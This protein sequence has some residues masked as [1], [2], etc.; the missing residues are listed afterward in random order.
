MNA[1]KGLANNVQTMTD[2][3]CEC[4]YGALRELLA[5]LSLEKTARTDSSCKGSQDINFPMRGRQL[6]PES[7]LAK[8]QVT[9]VIDAK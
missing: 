2:E 9:I 6:R 1:A 5:Y 4:T 3:G 7:S 8:L